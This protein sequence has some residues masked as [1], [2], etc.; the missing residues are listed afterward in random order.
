[1][2]EMADQKYQIAGKYLGDGVWTEFSGLIQIS[3][4]GIV[5]GKNLVE[6]ERKRRF[7]LFGIKVNWQG[8]VIL[9]IKVYDG[10]NGPKSHFYYQIYQK[11]KDDN[12]LSGRWVGNWSSDVITE[13]T[14]LILEA[15]IS[16]DHLGISLISEIEKE[17]KRPHGNNQFPFVRMKDVM[18]RKTW[19][20]NQIQTSVELTFTPFPLKQISGGEKE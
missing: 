1:M 20:R 12:N 18:L 5:I 8:P 10:T 6:G 3:A 11:E 17:L 13:A 2:A 15:I 16:Q 19:E 7:H 4:E 9:F 14:L